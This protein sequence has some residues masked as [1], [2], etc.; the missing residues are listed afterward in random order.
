[1]SVGRRLLDWRLWLAA[2]AAVAI[3]RVL[4]VPVPDALVI[5]AAVAVA[6]LVLPD[7][8]SGRDM[9]WPAPV[10]NPHHGR[11]VE[12]SRLTWSLAG[13][14]GRVSEPGV[15][16]IREI[17]TARLAR[18]GLPLSAGF[19][20]PADARGEAER[21]AARAALGPRAWSVLAAPSSRLPSVA[22]VAECVHALEQILDH[23]PA[24][25][26]ADDRT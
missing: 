11:R 20:G 4:A 7:L 15:R 9:D 17:A 14:D 19:E 21:R 5:G 24:R 22:D 6:G 23:R 26:D 25:E 16:R 18:V 2:A 3:A 10:A 1:M 8:G 12:V 13:R